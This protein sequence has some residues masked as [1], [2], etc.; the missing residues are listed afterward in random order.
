MHRQD[1]ADRRRAGGEGG[2]TLTASHWSQL[3]A[4]L[5][6]WQLAPHLAHTLFVEK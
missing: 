5:H 1:V 3:V 4:D 2:M 6:M